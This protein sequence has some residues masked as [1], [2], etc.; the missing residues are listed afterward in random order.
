MANSILIEAN[1]YKLKL[2]SSMWKGPVVIYISNEQFGNAG[3]EIKDNVELTTE[4]PFTFLELVVSDWDKYLTPWQAEAGMK[5]REFQGWAKELLS[6]IEENVITII[7]EYARDSKIYIAGYSLAGLFSLWSL[8]ESNLFDGAACCSGSMWYPGWKE[9]VAQK[10][11]QKNSSVYL[12]LGKKEK[13]SKHSLMKNVEDNMQFQY[14]I[15]RQDS[16]IDMLQMDWHEGGHFNN[17]SERV[18]MGIRW[19]IM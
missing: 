8:Y 13:N 14:D 17:T 11:L 10:R 15:L 3:Q 1:E 6:S 2:L 16:N 9:Y 5:G 18:V 19:L 4:V 12:S 7:K